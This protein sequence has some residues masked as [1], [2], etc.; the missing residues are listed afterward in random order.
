MQKSRS[1]PVGLVEVVH[2]DK[3]GTAAKLAR[4]YDGVKFR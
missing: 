3:D 4:G 2:R 1:S